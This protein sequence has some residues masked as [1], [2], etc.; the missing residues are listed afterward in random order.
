MKIEEIYPEEIATFIVESNVKLIKA[1]NDEDYRLA[2]TI[3]TATLLHLQNHAQRISEG[4]AIR[5]QN[6]YSLLVRQN[7]E[8][9]NALQKE[10][11][12][13]N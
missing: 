12:K 6:V 4:T 9:F 10:Y 13:N 2:S 11:Q 8:A 5:M 7:D 3:K 1:I